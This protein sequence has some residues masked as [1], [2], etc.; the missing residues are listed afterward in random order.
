MHARLDRAQQVRLLGGDLSDLQAVFRR[1]MLLQLSRRNQ[2]HGRQEHTEPTVLVTTHRRFSQ[3]SQHQPVHSSH[4]PALLIETPITRHRRGS[5]D[6]QLADA[7]VCETL[8]SQRCRTASEDMADEDVLLDED[9]GANEDFENNEG[10]RGVHSGR[11]PSPDTPSPEVVRGFKMAA[12]NKTQVL[13]YIATTKTLCIRRAGTELQVTDSTGFPLLDVWQKTSCFS[14]TWVLESY[15]RTVLLLT[16][17]GR[18][19]KPWN[20]NQ[21]KSNFLEVTDEEDEVVGYFQVGEPFVVQNKDR[22]PIA[23][24][25]GYES[26]DGRTIL[27]QCVLECSG[28]E[29][30][31][32]E[33]RK[34]QL[35]QL[36]FTQLAISFQLKLLIVAAAIRIAAIP[37]AGCVANPPKRVKKR[38]KKGVCCSIV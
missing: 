35:S 9:C 20:F 14:S 16:D 19:W 38:N 24:F 25:V 26:G 34:A 36:R 1:S 10:G 4:D 32:L 29:V 27:F 18:S 15:G 12:P 6:S 5:Q 3:H 28:E 23:R 33:P 13:N 11:R 7:E 31:R 37:S 8:R 22:T 2:Y 30:G 21:P 17:S